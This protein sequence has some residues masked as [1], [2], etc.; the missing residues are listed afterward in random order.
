MVADFEIDCA[1]Y[2]K[3]LFQKHVHLPL[4]SGLDCLAC[5]NRRDV[6]M[7]TRQDLLKRNS[8]ELLIVF[9]KQFVDHLQNLVGL[10]HLT[11]VVFLQN[12]EA[13]HSC[14][15]TVLY[16]VVHCPAVFV[17]PVNLG[18]QY[19]HRL[20]YIVLCPILLGTVEHDHTDCPKLF[21]NFFG[22]FFPFIQLDV[23]FALLISHVG[24]FLI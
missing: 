10:L 8:F 15:E 3:K 16:E 5:I 23:P 6:I 20:S 2:D 12:L 1:F 19:P 9:R 13:G 14:D 22:P 18:L 17:N 4:I 24:L 7:Q 21:Q 11:C